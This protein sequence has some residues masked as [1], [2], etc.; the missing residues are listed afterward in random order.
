VVQAADDPV[1]AIIRDSAQQLVMQLYQ[2][3]TAKP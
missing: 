1:V 3:A 2:Q